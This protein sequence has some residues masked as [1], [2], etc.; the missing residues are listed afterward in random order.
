MWAMID[1]RRADFFILCKGRQEKWQRR[2]VFGEYN[3]EGE[4]QVRGGLLLDIG[5]AG[6]TACGI[7]ISDGVS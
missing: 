7:A 1:R 5:S 3:E 6:D 2:A 4:L